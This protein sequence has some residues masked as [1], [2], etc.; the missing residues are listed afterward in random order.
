MEIAGCLFVSVET[1]V[2]SSLTRNVLTE[3]LPSNGFF[4]IY[5]VQRERVFG[6]LLASYGLPLWLYYS[7]FLASCHSMYV[8]MCVVSFIETRRV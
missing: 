5:S 7:G 3:L 1:F 2:E 6:G 8:C 4:R